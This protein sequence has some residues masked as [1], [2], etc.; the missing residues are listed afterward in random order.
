MKVLSERGALR[1]AE[2]AGVYAG[3]LAGIIGARPGEAD[4]IIDQVLAVL[5]PEDHWIVVRAI[6]YS[7]LPDWKAL[8]RRFAP[9]MPTRS[10]MIGEYLDDKLPPLERV[11]LETKKPGVW[12]QLKG[13][14]ATRE[15]KRIALTYDSS[16]EPKDVRPILNEV[17]EAADT[18]ETSRIRRDALAA[19]DE[20]KLKGPSSW[21]DLS[22]AGKVAEGTVSLGC[23]AAA[24][25]GFGAAVGV[26]CVVGG[27]VGSAALSAFD[28]MK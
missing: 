23:I 3:F 19:I 1:D 27:A 11:P 6:V 2:A 21:R 4:R 8:L 22:L 7:G 13:Y 25:S 12:E 9:R 18:M 15:P 17:I 20:L 16:P 5:P 14:F 10:V 28:P 26:P 24:A